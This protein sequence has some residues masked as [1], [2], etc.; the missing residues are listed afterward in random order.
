MCFIVMG[1]EKLHVTRLLH[2][3]LKASYIL[4]T[5]RR[6]IYKEIFSINDDEV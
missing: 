3:Y 6:G 4:F 1:M 2:K 5:L